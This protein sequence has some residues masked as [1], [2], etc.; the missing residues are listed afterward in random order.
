M[1][2]LLSKFRKLVEPLAVFAAPVSK[3]LGGALA[4]AIVVQ[5][6]RYGIDAS[7]T[8]KEAA[9]TISGAV[10]TGGIVWLFPKNRDK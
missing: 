4:G 10:V 1:K 9:D 3:A 5:L 8:V 7:M 6:S 2:D